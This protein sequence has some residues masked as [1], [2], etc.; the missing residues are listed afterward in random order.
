MKYKIFNFTC[1]TPSLHRTSLK[2]LESV[3]AVS[4]VYNLTWT[5]MQVSYSIT[6]HESNDKLLFLKNNFEWKSNENVCLWNVLVLNDN[7]LP[8]FSFS[9][10]VLYL[11][12]I[13]NVD[14]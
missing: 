8:F 7:F 4:K 13:C 11:I 6:N 12:G 9:K 1:E 2:I 14:L 3:I 5:N 10:V